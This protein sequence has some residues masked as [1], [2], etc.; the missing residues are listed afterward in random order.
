MS[1]CNIISLKTLWASDVSNYSLLHVLI[2]FLKNW[3][4]REKHWSVASRVCPD[5]GS[6]PQ[7]S[8]CPDGIKPATFW[9]TGCRSHQPSHPA[10]T[11]TNIFKYEKYHQPLSGDLFKNYLLPL[12]YTVT[13]TNRSHI[14]TFSANYI[15]SLVKAQGRTTLHLCLQKGK[16]RRWKSCHVDSWPPAPQRRSWVPG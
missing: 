4:E 13:T 12:K 9:C 2:V 6:T 5:Q 14:L 3:F 8:M 7:R 16:G 15:W 11:I 10:R 1:A